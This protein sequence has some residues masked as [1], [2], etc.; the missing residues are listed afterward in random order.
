ME[1]LQNL[2]KEE[3]TLINDALDSLCDKKT[4]DGYIAEK[5]LPGFLEIFED[6]PDVRKKAEGQ[7]KKHIQER[8]MENNSVVENIRILQG[9]LLLIKR[10][11]EANAAVNGVN[12]L[13]K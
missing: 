3:F 11:L 9:K 7:I 4:R 12:D 1:N 2:T 13:L 10:E 5:A 6:H 8:K